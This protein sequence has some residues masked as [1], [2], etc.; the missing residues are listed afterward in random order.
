MRW[1][2]E[3]TVKSVRPDSITA[4][5]PRQGLLQPLVLPKVRPSFDRDFSIGILAPSTNARKRA[6]N[7]TDKGL[8][9]PAKLN[10]HLAPAPTR[11]LT[12]VPAS[13]YASGSFCKGFCSLY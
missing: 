9:P 3:L 13:G 10:P 1:P 4:E 5:F 2:A 12:L 8:I 6:K 7:P 11:L